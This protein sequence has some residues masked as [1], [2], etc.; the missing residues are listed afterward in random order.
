MPCAFWPI[1]LQGW[2]EG[3][4][5]LRGRL[6][7]AEH[8]RW[9][10]GAWG[11]SRGPICRPPVNGWRGCFVYGVK[12]LVGIGLEKVLKVGFYL[13][14]RR[15]R[16]SWRRRECFRN[17]SQSP[18]AWGSCNGDAA[19]RM[20]EEKMMENARELGRSRIQWIIYSLSNHIQWDVEPAG[21]DPDCSSG[22]PSFGAGW[23]DDS[24]F[25]PDSHQG[26]KTPLQ[27]HL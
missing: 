24:M 15:N 17:R 22:I 16:G 6:V 1:H 4:A 18:M 5:F 26:W 19:A 7:W 9:R 13:F 2:Q 21:L 12:T 23:V 8:A 27:L 3:R 20:A 25:H 14:F 10:L 11:Q